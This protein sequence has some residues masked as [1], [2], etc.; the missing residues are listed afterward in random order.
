MRWGTTMNLNRTDVMADLKDDS[1]TSFDEQLKEARNLLESGN[2]DGALN[3]FKRLE[4][5][6]VRAAEL[7]SFMGD[8]LLKNGQTGEGIRYKTLHKILVGTFKIAQ[9]ECRRGKSESPPI[10]QTL[11][12]REPEFQQDEDEEL[13]LPV[14]SAMGEQLLKQGHFYE[15]ETLFN[16]LLKSDPSNDSIKENIRLARKKRNEKQVVQTLEAWLS[17]VT[18]IKNEWSRD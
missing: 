6:Y 16:K 12:A 14:T 9:E 1:E 7:F 18:K 8:A 4:Q 11:E 3:L 5:Q 13:D 15:A 17:N 10:D 2:I